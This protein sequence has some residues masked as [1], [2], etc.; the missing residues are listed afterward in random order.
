M[1]GGAGGELL[2]GAVGEVD[3]DLLGGVGHGR[4]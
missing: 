4:Y 1:R 3:L 2:D